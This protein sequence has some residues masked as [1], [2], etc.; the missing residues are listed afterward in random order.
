[1]VS[2]CIN[3]IIG[4]AFL[5][6]TVVTIFIRG[7]KKI[8]SLRKPKKWSLLDFHTHLFLSHLTRKMNRPLV[9]SSLC[10]L[11]YDDIIYFWS[12]SIRLLIAEPN[13]LVLGQ[14][15]CCF[16]LRYIIPRPSSPASS[17]PPLSA[18]FSL[19]IPLFHNPPSHAIHLSLPLP[20]W[21]LSNKHYCRIWEYIKN[22]S[23]EKFQIESQK[24][25]YFF[26]SKDKQR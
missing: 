20:P 23:F 5:S 3:K 18:P 26:I 4:I 10:A 21:R 24:K 22:I 6:N 19:V 9:C 17:S 7:V 2:Q 14:C 1:M 25:R 12:G 15:T 8:R 13:A 11:L 16:N